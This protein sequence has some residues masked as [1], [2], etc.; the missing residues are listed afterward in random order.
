MKILNFG[1]CNID[2]VYSLDHIVRAGETETTSAMSVFPGGKGLNQSIAL[3]RAG[4]EVFHAGCI[5][6]GG[7]FLRDLLA[8]NGVDTSFLR[9]VDGKNGHAVIQ[10]SREGENS[11]FLYPGSNECITR[12]QIDET[13][14]HFSEGDLLL[15]Q[16]EVNELGYLVE[17]AHRRGLRIVLNPSPYNETIRNLN[18]GMLSCLILNEVEAGGITGC[19]SSEE[20]LV[21]FRAH[22]PNLSV[23]LTLGKKGCVYQDAAQ[24]I[25]HGAFR[26]TA[27]DTTAAGDTFTGYFVAGIS[28]GK[29]M[30]EILRLASC[31]SAIS[32]SRMGA[33]P[34]I[35]KKEEVLALLPSMKTVPRDAK[36]RAVLQKIEQ[37]LTENLS[38][39]NLSELS[40]IL[41]YSEAYTAQLV[42]EL[43][44]RG[45]R[46]QVQEKRLRR[47]ATLLLSAELSVGE[48]IRAVGYENES[49]FRAAFRKRY[50]MN[51]LEYRKND[52]KG[53]ENHE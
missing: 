3:S 24:C 25:S 19:D 46:E 49:F 15:L 1:S 37:Y 48:I 27:V 47:A 16:N 26:V 29:P 36:R 43:T 18:F 4:G 5:G 8:G 9:T 53:E 7:E 2:Y 44:G 11:I 23:M 13:L 42:K 10:V 35:P 38:R 39:A 41:G 30:D 33:A 32:V 40:A 51:P 50:G 22:Y 6:E 21:Y 31:A 20:A 17:A 12:E 45:F 14:S 28:E 52:Q 34:S